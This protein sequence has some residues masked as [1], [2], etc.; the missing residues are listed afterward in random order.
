LRRLALAIAFAAAIPST[1]AYA[2]SPRRRLAI[3]T[4]LVGPPRRLPTSLA[5]FVTIES[6]CGLRPSL[7][8]ASYDELYQETAD[9]PASRVA[10]C[11]S[12]LA[13]V[14]EILRRA[15]YS[16]AL[17][18]V[19]V[20]AATDRPLLTIEL[21]DTTVSKRI[22]GSTVEIR[23]AD[24]LVEIRT[25]AE[26]LLNDAGIGVGGRIVARVTPA[27]ADVQLLTGNASDP[28]RPKQFTVPAGRYVVR[29]RR[30][31]FEPKDAEVVVI[32]GR[33]QA[34]GLEL[35]EIPGESLFSSPWF[36]I[37]AAGVVIAGGASATF[38]ATRPGPYTTVAVSVGR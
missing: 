17:R 30:E 10:D 28:G 6:V 8:V 14:G 12:D 25:E 5:M 32:A 15:G 23:G 11:G 19:L 31:G 7:E 21:I 13:C 3:V 34:V 4:Q 35:R 16:L 29:A 24:P 20:S 18:A 36:W 26:Q 33:E 27:D 2:D 38:V 37:A 9:Q 1:L 22:G